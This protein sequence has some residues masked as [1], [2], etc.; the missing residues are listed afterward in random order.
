MQAIVRKQE[1]FIE[2]TWEKIAG[3]VSVTA[4]RIQ[5]GMPYTTRYGKYDDC[6]ESEPSWWTNSFWSGILWHMYKGTGVETFKQFAESIEAKLDQVLLEYDGLHHDVGFMWLL[7][8]V[9]NHDLTGSEQARRRAMLA[10][11]ILSSRGNIAGGYIRAWNGNNAG[12]AIID[13][14]M[15]IPLLFWASRTSGDNRFKHLA[16]MHADKSLQAFVREDGSV[17]H[18]VIFDE[19]TGELLETPGGQGVQSGSSWSRGQSWAVYGFAQAYHWTGK[20]EYLDAAKRIAH[21]TLANL[22]LTDYIPLCDYR[23]P[24][25][26]AQLDSS[27]GAITAC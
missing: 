12:W 9:M 2:E 27:A 24:A 13:C 5:D 11:S 7:T 3:K 25:D 16:M 14:M 26:S 15:N 23:Q 21:Y 22:A 1:R 19:S 6:Q 18:I 8:S 17:N 10:A 20:K 4:N